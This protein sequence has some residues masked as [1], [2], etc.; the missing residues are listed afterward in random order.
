MKTNKTIL[1]IDDDAKNIYA[2]SAVLKAHQYKSVSALSAKQGIEMLNN[3]PSI[4]LVLMDMMMP[5]MDGYQALAHL[6]Q[7]PQFEKLPIICV[8]AQAM[9]GDKEKCLQAGANDYLSKPVE[10]PK[11]LEVLEKH[12]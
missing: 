9:T 7:N 10:I 2:L 6:R 8:T 12:L 11:L 1:V 4:A 5:E 3:D